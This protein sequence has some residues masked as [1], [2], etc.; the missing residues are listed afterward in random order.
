[1]LSTYYTILFDTLPNKVQSIKHFKE[2]MKVVFLRPFVHS[3]VPNLTL[4]NR[5]A[6]HFYQELGGQRER[7]KT[8]IQLREIIN[9][10]SE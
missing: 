2:K 3:F 7:G 1:M 8:F 6:R 10:L 4:S 5:Q 9:A